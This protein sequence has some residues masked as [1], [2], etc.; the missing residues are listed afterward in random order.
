MP[1]HLRPKLRVNFTKLIN[2]CLQFLT[3]PAPVPTAQWVVDNLKLPAENSDTPGDFDIWNV[4][5]AFGIYAALDDPKTIEIYC[6]KAAQVAWTTLIIGWM[7][8]II[9]TMPGPMIT[10][11]S[12]DGAARE[13]SLEK[14]KPIVN[15][16]PKLRN[17]I[18]VSGSTRSGNTVMFKQFTGGFLKL[19]S[20]NNVRS[21]KSTPAR[22]VIV[23]EPD[24]ANENV[25]K[26]GDSVTL[27]FERTKRMRNA[28]RVLG[29]TPSVKGFSRVEERISK[30]DKRVL[31]VNCHDCGEAHVLDFENV[32]GWQ[33]DEDAPGAGHEIYGHHS[34]EHAIYACPHCGS[35]WDDWQ[36]KENIKQ[37]VRDAM[38]AGDPLCGW[39]A[40]AEFDGVAGFMLLSELYS[41]L[42]GAGVGALVRDYLEAEYYAAQG[43]ENKKIVFTNSKLAKAYEYEDGRSNADDFKDLA[44]ADRASQHKE[45]TVPHEGL[46]LTIGID[47]QHDRLAIIVRAWGRGEQ[48]WLVYWGEIYANNSCADKSDAVWTALDAITFR[49]FKHASG[50]GL[51]ASAISIDSSDG[52]TNDAV[53]HWVR[54]R[55]RKYPGVLTMAIKGSSSTANPEI[56]AQPK[57]RGIDHKDPKKQT[58]ADRKGVKVYMVGTQR[59]KDLIAA[60]MDLPGEGPGRM[61][62]YNS[63]Q[64]RWDY[65]DQMT[66]EA[67][68][69][70]KTQRHKKVWALKSGRRCEAWDCEVYAMH[71]ARAKRIHLLS[72]KD[73]DAIEA[74]VLQSDLF[75][76]QLLEAQTEQAKAPAA[77]RRKAVTKSIW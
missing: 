56:F 38:A 18:D 72:P 2:G 69:P 25:G 4:P 33:G 54:D 49:T 53:Y 24:D 3:P 75:K 74:E 62:Y 50:T 52:H 55:S 23:E 15:E 42:P 10:M 5:Y 44:A 30:S 46:M 77:P 39:V 58:K 67:K 60:R 1:S 61:H 57:L 19:I 20:S 21:V 59:A 73:W 47:V 41:C 71:A 28:K 12:A 22:Y 65:F 34:P 31:P 13:F 9:D 70:S 6:S 27:L 51:Y 64:L 35:V 26:Q 68:I 16:T 8:K 37:T 63:E 48:S 11:F 45:F 36:R 14:L 43:D 66:A 32:V 17:R 7:G 40:T 29:G 76:V